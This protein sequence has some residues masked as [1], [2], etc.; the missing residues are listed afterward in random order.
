MD[1]QS[2]VTE[3]LTSGILRKNEDGVPSTQGPIIAAN[4]NQ[5]DA[6]PPPNTYSVN[7]TETRIFLGFSRTVNIL[8]DN[9]DPRLY[10]RTNLYL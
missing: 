2:Q 1:N 7:K 3:P 9:C 8:D 5:G 10:F 6:I 4:L